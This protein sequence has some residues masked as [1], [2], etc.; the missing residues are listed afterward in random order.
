MRGKFSKIKGEILMIPIFGDYK[1]FVYVCKPV[2]II[3][4][5]KEIKRTVVEPKLC[6][7]LY[8]QCND[9]NICKFEDFQISIKE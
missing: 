4:R 6:K 7:Y 8:M 2:P 3:V 5:K 9:E 1:A